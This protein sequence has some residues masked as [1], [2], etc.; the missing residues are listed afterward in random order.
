MLSGDRLQQ[1]YRGRRLA[2]LGAS[3]FIGRWVAR[4]LTA[5]GA[6]LSLIVRDAGSMEALLPTYGIR[7]EIVEQDLADLA[8]VREVL[9]EIRPSVV[10]NL[11]GYGVD[12]AE[13]DEH[14]AFLINAA[15]VRAVAEA[16]ASLQDATWKGQ[17]VVHVGSALEYGV[18]KGN[19]AESSE[20]HP[21][22]LYGRSKLA[23]TLGLAEVCCGSALRGVTARLFTVYGPGE[24]EQRL[25]PSLLRTADAG[26]PLDLTLGW[27][28]RDFTFVE[29]VAEALLRLGAT[30]TEPGEVVN[31]ASGRF[32]TVRDFVETAARV[33]S[34]ER[35]L[36][37]FGAVPVRDEEM[38]H[39]PVS[40]ERLQKRTGWLPDI[41]VEEGIRQTQIFQKR[42]GSP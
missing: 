7:S 19:L 34:I 28:Q 37:R 8:A 13:Q 26:R 2:V 3:G 41:D 24:H 27:Q 18:A 30:A 38:E 5:C 31:V 22:T 12:H 23:G 33:L 21:T 36:L 42:G 9:T 40:V 10:F 20:P 29:D 17:A 11:A 6:R 14:T 39:E 15:L 4:R 16:M 1:A 32:T 25:L 35:D